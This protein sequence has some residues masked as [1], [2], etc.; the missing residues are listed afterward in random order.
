MNRFDMFNSNGYYAPRYDSGVLRDQDSHVVK[1]GE[2]IADIAIMYNTTIEELMNANNL[3]STTVYAGQTLML[4]N[5]DYQEYL[6]AQGD[7]L[8]KIAEKYG[9]TVEEL[10]KINNLDNTVIYPNQAILVPYKEEDGMY[11]KEYFTKQGDTLQSVANQF[12]VS[13]NLLL[14]YNDVLNYLLAPE[15]TVKIPIGKS[16]CLILEQDTVDTILSKTGM[17]AKEVIEMNSE[18]WLIPGSTIYVK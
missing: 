17:T 18:T 4:P 14:M 12:G 9:T 6:V 15:Q 1:Q 11:Y 3:S 5:G 7:N 16:T 10:I 13:T 8:Y 2:T